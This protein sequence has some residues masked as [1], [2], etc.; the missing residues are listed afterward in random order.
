MD[1]TKVVKGD[2]GLQGQKGEPGTPGSEGKEFDF[3]FNFQYNFHYLILLTVHYFH[4][5]GYPG[6]KGSI[7][8]DVCN[9]FLG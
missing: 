9:L 1:I 3:G 5:T 6:E 8:P 7:G 4:W 2:T